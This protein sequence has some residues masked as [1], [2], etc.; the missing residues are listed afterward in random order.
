MITDYPDVD[1]FL[2]KEFSDQGMRNLY[3]PDQIE[4]DFKHHPDIRSQLAKDH[5]LP[6]LSKEEKEIELTDC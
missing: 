2:V 4:P 1:T 6:N 5:T 3:G